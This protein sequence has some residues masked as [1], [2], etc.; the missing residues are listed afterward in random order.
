MRA[1]V[2]FHQWDVADDAIDPIAIVSEFIWGNMEESE[3]QRIFDSAKKVYRCDEAPDDAFRTAWVTLAGVHE[4]FATPELGT[5]E[6]A[7]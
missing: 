6:V 5:V 3:V 2:L 4:L 1:L 7:P